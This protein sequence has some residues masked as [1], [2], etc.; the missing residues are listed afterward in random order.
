MAMSRKEWLDIFSGNLKDMMKEGDYSVGELSFATGIPQSTI[1]RYVNGERVP[2]PFNIVK[3]ARELNVPVNDLIDFY[4][5][6]E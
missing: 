3:L 4:E 6:I 1:S 2:T 5:P